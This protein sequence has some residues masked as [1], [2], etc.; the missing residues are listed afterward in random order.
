VPVANC[1]AERWVGGARRECL[2]WA[3]HP[4]P[5]SPRARADRICRSLQSR[6]AASR[7]TTAISRRRD[8]LGYAGW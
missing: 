4:R 6:T 5:A 3:D 7:L 2:D 1:Y 8:R